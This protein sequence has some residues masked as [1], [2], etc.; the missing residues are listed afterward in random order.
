MNSLYIQ[1]LMP[2]LADDARDVD[3]AQVTHIAG[4]LGDRKGH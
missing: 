4:V 3:V 2:I 1:M